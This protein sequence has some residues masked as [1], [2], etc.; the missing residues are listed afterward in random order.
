MHNKGILRTTQCHIF[1]NPF[2]PSFLFPS[3]LPSFLSFLWSW[4][5]EVGEQQGSSSTARL[6]LDP[7]L[8][9][10]CLRFSKAA[11]DSIAAL[12]LHRHRDT[13]KLES[14]DPGAPQAATSFC[15]KAEMPCVQPGGQT[16]GPAASA[17]TL[18]LLSRPTK[19][20]L[21]APMSLEPVV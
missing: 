7:W 5:Y 3:F 14:A 10:E 18:M 17:L 6:P 12:C 19:P 4:E 1:D 16:P 20:R 8:R 15:R 11:C 13:G 9:C 2:L 21:G